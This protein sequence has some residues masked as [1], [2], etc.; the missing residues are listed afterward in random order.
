VDPHL[1]HVDEDP[2]D[3]LV[4]AVVVDDPGVIGEQLAQGVAAERGRELVDVERLVLVGE[5]ELLVLERGR[6]DRRDHRVARHRHHGPVQSDAVAV[7]QGHVRV[8][9][10]DQPGEHGGLVD[11]VGLDQ[12]DVVVQ[13]ELLQG[14][15][16]R[17]DVVGGGVGLVA[18]EGHRE[19]GELA[20]DVGLDLTG[21]VAG[22]DA[23]LGDAVGPEAL[24]DP[25]HDR[26]A[27]DLEHGLV[28]RVA[29]R[30]HAPADA[31]REDDGLHARQSGRGGPR[32][33]PLGGRGRPTEFAG[34]RPATA[35]GARCP[36][37]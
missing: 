17:V 37:G 22:D 15:R 36:P 3:Q 12:H 1:L 24:D 28:P 30:P 9:G 7:D 20:V 31:R 29:E 35:A 11:Q 23:Q 33:Q 13:V 26:L 16:H 2:E 19:I 10:L 6:D 32:R 8:L 21:P 14:E 18:D 5:V 34:G 4:V 25:A 27:R